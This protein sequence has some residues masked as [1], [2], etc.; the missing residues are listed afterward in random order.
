M[1]ELNRRILVT[2]A[3]GFIG[4]NLVVRLSEL[5]GVTVSTF[6][7]GDDVDDLPDLI[8]RVD[9]VIH[10]AGENRPSDDGAFAQV[11]VGLTSALCTAIQREYDTQGR[12]V[13][14]ILASSTQAERD[15]PY[16]RSK[17]AA[18]AA[19]EKLFQTTGNPCVV[20]R[21]PGV[22][23]KW[24]KP[25]YNSVVATFCH[26]IARDLPIQINDPSAELRLVYIDDVVTAL[27]AALDAPAA[28]CVRATVNPEYAISLGEL[29]AQIRAFGN[30]RSTLMS[31]RVGTGLVRALYATYVS[32]LPEEKF[33]YEVV[34]HADPR[35]VFVE[36]LKTP[37]SGQF[38]YFTAHPG[39][40]RGGH[41]H[42]T[43]TEKFLVIKGEAL[44][45]FRH[46]LTNELIELRTS[47]AKPQVVDTIPGWSHDITNVGNDEMVVMLWANENFDRQKPD[48]VASKV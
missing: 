41:Y 11:N 46:L 32:Y 18:E 20:F 27:L 25:N 47:G 48:T 22:F 42:H 3:N 30:C 40:T 2:G 37:D 16:G 4:R 33:A 19:V 10:L 45:R 13:A 34:Q 8:A 38:S 17:F 35:G 14:L 7:R 5:S 39:I 26:N 44:F 15:N 23:G 36:M 21:L 6:V 43:K 24:C 31:E 28:G 12:R 9:A 1:N 29:A